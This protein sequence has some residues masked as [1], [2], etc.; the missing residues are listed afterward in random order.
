M[1]DQ[2]QRANMVKGIIVF[3]VIQGLG[4]KVLGIGLDGLGFRVQKNS[5]KNNR[6]II[7]RIIVAGR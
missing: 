3:M 2:I 5:T 1:L 4:F 7:L 6:T